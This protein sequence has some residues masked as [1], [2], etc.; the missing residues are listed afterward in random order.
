M[1]VFLYVS[2]PPRSVCMYIITLGHRSRT[3]YSTSIFS[4]M[5]IW[6][7]DSYFVYI[8]ALYPDLYVSN[9]GQYPSPSTLSGNTA[10]L[11]IAP[12]SPSKVDL[13]RIQ[14]CHSCAN[15]YLCCRKPFTSECQGVF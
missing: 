7:V 6:I 3:K 11:I 4:F 8:M 9:V 15:F 1:N 10:E 12:C 14:P 13:I 2:V 5:Y